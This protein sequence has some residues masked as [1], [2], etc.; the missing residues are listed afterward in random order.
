MLRNENGWLFQLVAAGLV[1]FGITSL[2]M[3]RYRRI[4]DRDMMH[5]AKRGMD[6]AAASVKS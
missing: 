6:K 3:A 4:E 5:D 2:V 1:A